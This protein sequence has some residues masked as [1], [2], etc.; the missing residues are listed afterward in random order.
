[1]NEFEEF[2]PTRGEQFEEFDVTAETEAEAE[3]TIESLGGL[4]DS[5]D[6]VK[7]LLGARDELESRLMGPA[8]A[9]A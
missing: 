4:T 8:G 1:M 6:H 5:E 2:D 9:K 3:A 7:S